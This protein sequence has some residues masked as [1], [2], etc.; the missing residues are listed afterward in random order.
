MSPRLW[1]RAH[2]PTLVMFLLC[3][4]LL[5]YVLFICTV[6]AARKHQSACKNST[7][8]W[9]TYGV[10]HREVEPNPWAWI[11]TVELDIG[12][13]WPVHCWR[14]RQT[15]R[16]WAV[17]A[18]SQWSRWFPHKCHASGDNCC[19]T[20]WASNRRTV[21]CGLLPGTHTGNT[22]TSLFHYWLDQHQILF[23][24]F[25]LL[26]CQ[27]DKLKLNSISTSHPPTGDTL[28]WVLFSYKFSHPISFLHMNLVAENK[29]DLLAIICSSIVTY[30]SS[31]FTNYFRY[32]L[33]WLLKSWSD[34]YT[35]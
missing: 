5:L 33:P 29:K 26:T 1:A 3:V 2:A 24:I 9:P 17:D 18:E 32:L 30:D 25:L 20:L 4:Q 34:A 23:V 6:N 10:A 8:I 27:K 11:D 14:L 21:D 12:Q 31:S 16:A 7:G 19:S 28:V 13:H 22:S 15:Q 35:R